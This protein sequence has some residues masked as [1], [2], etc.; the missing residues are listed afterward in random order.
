MLR[1]TSVQNKKLL[2]ITIG[3]ALTILFGK[4]ECTENRSIL[5]VRDTS[6]WAYDISSRKEVEI[7][8]SADN[9]SCSQ[10]GKVIAF[11]RN[12]NIWKTTFP[13]RKEIQ[14]TKFK[15]SIKN[16][17][18]NLSWS[19]D[20]KY[21]LFER[22]EQYLL[23]SLERKH[24]V[25]WPEGAFEPD[26]VPIS[27]STIWLIDIER[28]SA[29]KFI[30]FTGYGSAPLGTLLSRVGSPS[31]SPDNKRIAF[32]RDGD[33]WVA[34]I[35]SLEDKIEKRVQPIAYLENTNGSSPS[36]TGVS[37]ISWSII[38]GGKLIFSVSRMSGSGFGEIWIMGS[39]GSNLKKISSEGYENSPFFL[40]ENTII[41]T[42]NYNIRIMN[43][44]GT[45]NI[46]LIHNAAKPC[47][48]PGSLLSK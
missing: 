1:Y 9:P 18:R 35:D 36:S 42:D 13:E 5:F 20:S 29:K 27:L 24:P 34:T 3:I 2:S 38:D 10:D 47:L 44:D 28:S 14:I 43:I 48:C 17:I 37:K 41:F 4:A 12:N 31:W 7:I 45:N 16:E 23:A 26:K 8:K 39:D 22:D 30:G 46:E 33:I 6:I 40:T 11:T 21:I 19:N 32:M 15:S 25:V